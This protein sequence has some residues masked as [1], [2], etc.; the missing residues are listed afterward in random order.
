MSSSFLRGRGFSLIELM[1]SMAIGS[2]ILI[3]AAS[4]L[5][6]SGDS[7]ERVNGGVSTERE[8][9]AMITQLSADLA[10]AVFHPCEIIEKSGAAWPVDRLGFLSLQPETAQT[11]LG[12]I[13]DLCAVNYYIKDLTLGGETIRCLMRGFHESNDT[14]QA[15]RNEGTALLFKPRLN[16]DEPI[17]FGV[18]SF[19]AYPKHRD[20]AGKWID[21][22]KNDKVG[23]EVFEVK[24]V[25]ARPNLARKLKL[26]ADW[27]GSSNTGKLLGEAN[28]QHQNKNL[29]TYATIL[30]FGNHAEQ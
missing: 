2:V 12:H 7:Y 23:P 29:E 28:Q 21:W 10:T 19:Q 11:E 18:V 22:V 5:G 26:P 3:V 6:I 25:V 13:G 14:F 1:F 15:L 4:M 20:R 24:I 16:L 9:R 27:D 30:R 17:A 8:A